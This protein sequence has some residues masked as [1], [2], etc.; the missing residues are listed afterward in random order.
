MSHNDKANGDPRPETNDDDVKDEAPLN[1]R[2]RS[3]ARVN[4]PISAGLLLVRFIDDEPEVLLVHPGG[5][6]FRGK[7]ANVWSVPKGIVGADEE[8]L[9]AALREFKE[10][11]GFDPPSPPYHFLGEA[12][13]RQKRVQAW[14]VRGDADPS[15]VRSNEFELEWPPKSGRTQSYPE[16]DRAAWFALASAETH[17]VRAQFPL[18]EAACLWIRTNSEG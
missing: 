8:P 9:A 4:L 2:T 1:A 6:F 15:L 11:T 16:V 5:P 10:E 12:Q 3:R 18:C 14:A 13:Q 7:D 17:V